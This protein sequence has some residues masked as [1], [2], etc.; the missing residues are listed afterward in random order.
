MGRDISEGIG[1]AMTEE[2]VNGVLLRAYAERKRL[3]VN[4]SKSEVMHLNGR[5][6]SSLPTFMCGSV[7]LPPKDQFKNLGML[8]DKRMNLK[9]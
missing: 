8:V 6:C 1:G 7:A 9:V 2:V 5:S 3:T 4:T